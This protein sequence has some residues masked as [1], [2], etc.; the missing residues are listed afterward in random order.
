MTAADRLPL[1][2]PMPTGLPWLLREAEDRIGRLVTHPLR[3]AE[4]H[5]SEMLPARERRRMEPRRLSRLLAIDVVTRALLRGMDLVSLRVGKP[6]PNGHVAPPGQEEL[7]RETG[8]SVV[9][10]ARVIRDGRRAGWWTAHQP[11]LEYTDQNGEK[12]YCAFFSVYRFTEKFF[13]R[14]GLAK[15]LEK[16]RKAASER[17]SGRRRIFAHALLDARD[18][19][20]NM[21]HTKR[22]P[23]DPVDVDAAENEARRLIHLKF[24]LRAEH[25]D[26]GPDRIDAEA[27]RLLRL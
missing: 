21:R 4:L 27:R 17:A 5:G 23:R 6:L 1:R 24:R 25:P 9:R 12:A 15:R 26:W 18:R 16:E 8:L 7:A 19:L 13:R 20:R 3:F 22:A 14:L 10:I 2:T 11:R